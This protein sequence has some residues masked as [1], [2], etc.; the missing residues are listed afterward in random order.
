MGRDIRWTRY[1][2]T[3]VDSALGR[4]IDA[5]VAA[6]VAAG[7]PWPDR[8]RASVIREALDLGLQQMDRPGREAT[9]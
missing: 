1:L 6:R 9:S 2:S 7:V 8:S 3:N 5:A 4:R